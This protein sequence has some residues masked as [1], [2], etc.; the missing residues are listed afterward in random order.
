MKI[1]A[2]SQRLITTL[3]V[4]CLLLPQALWAQRNAVVEDSPNAGVMAADLV[5]AR[6]IGLVLTVAGTAAFIVSLPFTLLAGNASDAAE[7]LMIA[8]AALTFVRCLGCKQVGYSYRD[9]DKNNARK[10][11]KSQEEAE[12][13]SEAEKKAG[14]VTYLVNFSSKATATCS[15]TNALISPPIAAISLTREDEI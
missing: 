4:G 1:K 8:P 10:E 15:G 2:K 12:A 5:V 7:K 11:R 6:P 14:S 3:V 9:I 13:Q